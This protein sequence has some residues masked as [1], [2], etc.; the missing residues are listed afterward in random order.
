MRG[1]LSAQATVSGQAPQTR[2]RDKFLFAPVRGK[3]GR[4]HWLSRREVQEKIVV[5]TGLQPGGLG[6]PTAKWV[7]TDVS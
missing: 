3:N 6:F 5:V 7:V 1:L 4:L 2:T